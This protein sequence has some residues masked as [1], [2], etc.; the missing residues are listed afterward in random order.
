[1]APTDTRSHWSPS[2]SWLPHRRGR[3]FP[4]DRFFKL[5]LW[6]V[7]DLPFAGS[8]VVS[9]RIRSLALGLSLILLIDAFTSNSV[10]V[11]GVRWLLLLSESFRFSGYGSGT[12]RLLSAFTLPIT[13]GGF[14]QLF[15]QSLKL[16]PCASVEIGESCGVAAVVMMRGGFIVRDLPPVVRVVGDLK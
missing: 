16:A 5:C 10:G 7:R 14:R 1:M 2:Q 9:A 3:R 12:R 6:P 11:I 8:Y 15:S 4:L 13:D